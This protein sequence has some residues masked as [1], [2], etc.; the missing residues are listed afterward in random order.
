MTSKKAL[1][2][3]IL[4]IFAFL[5]IL[6][7][8]HGWILWQVEGVNVVAFSSFSLEVTTYF[9]ATLTTTFFFIGAVCYVVFRGE[10]MELPL[11]Q[12]SKDFEEQLDVKCEEI[13]TSTEE[14]LAKLG[15]REFQLKESMK[16][17]QKKFG[18][19][20]NKLKESMETH[21]KIL[22]ATQKKLLK[23]EHKIS[24]IQTA[25]KELPKLRKKL[26]AIEIVEK[27]LKSIKEIIAKFDSIPE[28]Y[29]T[30][31]NEIRVLE[32]K[33]LKPGTVRQLKLNGI[34]KIEDL[35]LKSP[36]EIA[37][38]KTMTEGEAKSLQSIMQLLMIPGVHHEDAVLLLKSGVNSK[39]ELALQDTFSLG[40]RV[41]KTVELY[42]KEG[43]I[44][45]D[46]KPTLEEI[47]SWIRLA[48][49]Q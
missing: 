15:L 11:Y 31:T 25:Q 3:W 46:E 21:E 22:K 30:S 43:K 49:T 23:M 27:N 45:E 2:V 26:Q 33:I 47:A 35:L 42:V 48:K 1:A 7:T 29:I 13:K 9:I 10:S 39:Q 41:A 38:T 5:A 36:L 18:E 28:P 12:L 37:L 24:K 17:L 32:G 14:A 6:G 34:K 44:K 4:I 19:L 16:V 40:A 8:L 20:D